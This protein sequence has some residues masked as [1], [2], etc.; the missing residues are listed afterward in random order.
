MLSW[1]VLLSSVFLPATDGASVMCCPSQ[2]AA[3][4][5]GE[6]TGAA[7]NATQVQET[8]RFLISGTLQDLHVCVCRWFMWHVAL[9][10][11]SLCTHL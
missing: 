4:C 6:G 10:V 5:G 1:D 3:R 7:V 2:G 11:P 8:N 9:I